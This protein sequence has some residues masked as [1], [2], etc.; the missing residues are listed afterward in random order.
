MAFPRWFFFVT[1]SSACIK[2][3]C[4][5]KE[6]HEILAQCSAVECHLSWELQ[7]APALEEIRAWWCH[8][9]WI[10]IPRQRQEQINSCSFGVSWLVSTSHC[11]SVCWWMEGEIFALPWWCPVRLFRALRASLLWKVLS[12]LEKD[13]IIN[14]LVV[15]MYIC[16]HFQCC[17][18]RWVTD[19]TRQCCCPQCWCSACPVSQVSTCS[20]TC[21]HTALSRG[22]QLKWTMLSLK[23][24][25]FPAIRLF[26]PGDL[27]QN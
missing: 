26:L 27:Q 21:V 23:G 6:W 3:V 15:N 25:G 16:R 13:R 8:R 9:G 17:S 22:H 1:L 10:T 19:G 14:I 18:V 5:Q 2:A 4:S 11:D 24:P 20:V 7:E 12:P